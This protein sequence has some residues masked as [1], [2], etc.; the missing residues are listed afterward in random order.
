M[1]MI[2]KLIKWIKGLFCRKKTAQKKVLEKTGTK[3]KFKKKTARK[4]KK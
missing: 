4:G 3:G 2:R 1:K